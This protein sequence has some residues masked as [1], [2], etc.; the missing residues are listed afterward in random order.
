MPRYRVL[1][2]DPDTGTEITVAEVYSLGGAVVVARSASALGAWIVIDTEPAVWLSTRSVGAI[3]DTNE[4]AGAERAA[5]VRYYRLARHLLST[6]GVDTGQ[7]DSE[8]PLT[9]DGQVP[10]DA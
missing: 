1:V 2:F 8:L 7:V 3:R 9:L 5:V 6:Q 10:I 4:I